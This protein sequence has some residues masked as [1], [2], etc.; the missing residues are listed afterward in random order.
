MLQ[1]IQTIYLLLVI[2]IAS[3]LLLSNIPLLEITIKDEG[4]DYITFC[5]STYAYFD[6]ITNILSLS[7][8]ILTS[9]FTI[10]SYRNFRL[11]FRLIGFSFTLSFLFYVLFFY[12]ISM[13]EQLPIEII[14]MEFKWGIYS[15]GII[16]IFLIL[17][18][19]AIQKDYRKI[20]S[21]RSIR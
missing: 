5:K 19:F 20:K 18:F 21:S 12:T 14:G 17:A 15:L 3:V 6:H 1:R 10:L 7:L 13:Y 4:I 8:I 16:D 9:L 11:Q 2:I